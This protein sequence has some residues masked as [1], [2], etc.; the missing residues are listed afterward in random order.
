M[1]QS[2]VI[3]LLGKDRPGLV[4][5]VAS[6]V[7]ENEGNWLESQMCSLGGQFAGI[8][9]VSIP[10]SKL[11]NWEDGL[12]TLRQ[13]GLQILLAEDQP[14]SELAAL[15]TAVFEIVG[16]DRPGI[17]RSISAQL[18]RHEVNVIK[19]SSECSSAPWSGEPLFRAQAEVQIPETCQIENLRSDLEKIAADLMI[20]ISFI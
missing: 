15:K 17:I 8:V 7:R 16:Q 10:E 4:E 12:E 20:D 6:S 3:T 5:S 14:D 18:A 2:F 19:L 11:Q 9:H 1:H 13:S